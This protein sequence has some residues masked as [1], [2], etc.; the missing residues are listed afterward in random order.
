MVPQAVRDARA[1]CIKNGVENA[2]FFEGRAEVVLPEKFEQEGIRADVIVVDPPRKGCDVPC[3]ETMLKMAPERIVY[4]S[5]DSAT[6]ARDLKILCAG[7]YEMKRVRGVDMF[8]M[9]V[10][11]ESIVLLSKLKSNKLKHINVE[12]EMDELDLTA[13]ESKVTYEV[14]KDYVLKQSGLKVSNLYIAQIKQKC[15]IIE[16]TNYNLPKSENSRQPQCP[17]EKE[18]AIVAALKHFGIV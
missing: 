5:C 8:P 17:A 1:N 10:H 3:L 6:L 11:C 9:T 2:L 4:V 14:I 13:A 7:G 12:L 16:R 18:Q 15:G